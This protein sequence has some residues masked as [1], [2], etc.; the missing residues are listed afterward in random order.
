MSGA[1]LR[2]AAEIRL[3]NNQRIGDFGSSAQCADGSNAKSAN[4]CSGSSSKSKQTRKKKSKQTRMKNEQIDS[5]SN[6]NQK[7]QWI[8][9]DLEC[10]HSE[11]F[12]DPVYSQYTDMSAVE[13][14]EL[15]ICEETIKYLIEETRKYALFRNC[16]DPNVSVNEMKC[17]IGTLILS[18]YN[19]LPGKRYYWESDG[20]MR[21]NL[22]Y[23]S[24]RRDRFEQISRFL[25]CA[26]NNFPEARDK[27]WK[28]RPLVDRV[29]QKCLEHFQP[30]E[31]LNYDESMVKYFGRHSCKQFIRG[32]PIRFGYKMWCLNTASGYLVNFEMY[33]GNSPRRNEEYEKLFG[34][35]S[36]PLVS[37]LDELPD[38]KRQLRYKL[39]F[40]NLF[41]G[42]TLLSYLK[43]KGYYA[44][45]TGRENRVPKKCSLTEKKLMLKKPRGT[46]ESIIDREDGIM[47]VR[48]V[49][50]GV[51]ATAT[52]CYGLNPLSTVKRY[53]QAEKSMLN[54]PRPDVVGKYNASMGGTDLMDENV[55]RYR[56]SIRGKKWWNCLF[57]W[58]VDV[59]IQNAW[60]LNRKSGGKMTQL[61]F[62][63]EIATT[64]LRSFGTP[65]KGPGRPRTSLSSVTMNRISDNLRYDK[66]DHLVSHTSGKKRRR[67]AG[68]GCSSSVRTMCIKCDVGLCLDCFVPFH[69]K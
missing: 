5:I 28:L 19:E 26:D 64:Y 61:M 25:H 49:D 22:I 39:Y 15:F 7:R 3:A 69:R 62:R 36:A 52:T 30:E 20:D 67:C 13:L 11:V 45:G 51:V 18:G 46:H 56:I 59:C 41:T 27:I 24:I 23:N 40:D 42:F 29:K 9:G 16:G 53:S 55:S 37:M 65:P 38:L 4:K 48:W 35:A 54:V 63:R 6:A 21:N 14:F 60:Q 32:K 2:A 31:H 10:N 57:T 66:I 12:P 8:V 50:N 34:K 68:E 44:T 47:L 58:I 33:Q 17:F 1:Q 43:N